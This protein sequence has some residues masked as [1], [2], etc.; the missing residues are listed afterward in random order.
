MLYFKI[1]WQY[2]TLIL[3]IKKYSIKGRDKGGGE[4]GNCNLGK[5]LNLSIKELHQF[6]HKMITP[7]KSLNLSNCKSLAKKIFTCHIACYN[8]W[9]DS[10]SLPD[11]NKASATCFSSILLSLLKYTTIEINILE[12]NS[13]WKYF[14]KKLF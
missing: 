3:N 4:R 14:S 11:L 10:W 13:N 7:R 9:Y 1:C 5:K 2:I 12:I 8:I 6:K